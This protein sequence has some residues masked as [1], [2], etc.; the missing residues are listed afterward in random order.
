M[1]LRSGKQHPGWL[2]IRQRGAEIDLAHVVRGAGLPQVSLCETY[3]NAGQAAD[4]LASLRR[5]RDLRGYRCTA[6]L[7]RDEYEF[8]LI[9]APNVPPAERAA[10]AR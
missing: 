9:E 3:G 4:A 2:A 7:E 1:Q 5:D 6:L 10:A 8:N